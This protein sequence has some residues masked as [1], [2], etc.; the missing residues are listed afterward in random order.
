MG[1]KCDLAQQSEKKGF[2]RGVRAS[3]SDLRFPGRQRGLWWGDEP[4]R[5]GEAEAGE[6]G[7]R[8]F[9][10]FRAGGFRRQD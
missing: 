7:S 9:V 3:P 4:A 1:C 5:G 10:R 8:L 2:G 6:W